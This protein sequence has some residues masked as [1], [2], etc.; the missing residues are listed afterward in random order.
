[1]AITIFGAL[2]MFAGVAFRWYSIRVLGRFFTRDVA[3][4][5][6]HQLVRAGPYRVLRHPSYTGWLVAAAGIGIGLN[7]WA[8]L[9]VL[10][11]VNFIAYRH[12]MNVEEAA[13]ID[14]FGDAYRAYQRETNR[15]IPGV[16]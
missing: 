8:S 3:I 9:I 11:A 2:L 13:L 5:P 16:Y 10:L 12:R 4:R 1:M 6:D 7:N 14:R 15:L